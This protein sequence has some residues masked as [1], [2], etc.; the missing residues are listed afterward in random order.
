MSRELEPVNE[1]EEPLICTTVMQRPPL[2]FNE[3]KEA[4][5]ED[6]ISQAESPKVKEQLQLSKKP[7]I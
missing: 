1:T 2:S 4:R 3:E 7:S 5:T 6:P